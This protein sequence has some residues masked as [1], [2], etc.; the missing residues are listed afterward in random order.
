M[1]VEARLNA[2]ERQIKRIQILQNENAQLKNKVKDLEAQI[3]S[4]AEKKDINKEQ[5]Q[6]LKIEQA[7]IKLDLERIGREPSQRIARFD[8][9]DQQIGNMYESISNLRY[10]TQQKL[11]MIQS[12][13]ADFKGKYVPMLENFVAHRTLRSRR[14]R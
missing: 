14:N 10:E 6:K 12:S 9:Q 11:G 7:K 13:I 8:S 4:K 3:K 1:S 5:C 2:L